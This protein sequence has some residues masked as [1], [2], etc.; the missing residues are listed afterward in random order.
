MPLLG[1]ES[2]EKTKLLTVPLAPTLP[3]AVTVSVAVRAGGVP[4]DVRARVAVPERPVEDGRHDDR[5]GRHDDRNDNRYDRNHQY[6]GN[7]NAIARQIQQLQYRVERTDMRDRI[8]EREAADLRRAV[9]NL[10]LQ[11]RDFN[12][13]GLSQRESQIL[14]Q[15]INQIREHLRYERRDNDGRRW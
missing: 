6:R 4:H 11:F 8:S 13:N 12:R 3:R 2:E 10:R 7:A 14:Q 9:Y 15:R 5:D 1:T